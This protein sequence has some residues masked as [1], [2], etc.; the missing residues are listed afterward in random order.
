MRPGGLNR[1]FKT[2]NKC[3]K[4]MKETVE[5]EILLWNEEKDGN[6]FL[7]FLSKTLGH[8]MLP[9]CSQQ[10]QDQVDVIMSVMYSCFGNFLGLMQISLLLLFFICFYV[11]AYVAL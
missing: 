5:I 3:D 7:S 2:N 10:K 8:Q 11:S 6:I 9:V 4:I 1:G